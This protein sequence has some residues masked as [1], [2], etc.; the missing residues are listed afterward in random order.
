[1]KEPV[2]KDLVA[3]FEGE[4]SRCLPRF[5]RFYDP[6]YVDLHLS[7]WAWTLSSRLTFFLLISAAEDHDEFGVE[8]AWSDDG[9]FPWRNPARPGNRLE[10]LPRVRE[11]LSF[12]WVNKVAYRWAVIPRLKW[13]DHQAKSEARKRGDME[14]VRRLNSLQDVPMDEALR[15]IGPLVNDAVQKPWSTVFRCSDA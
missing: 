9:L 11:D 7:F 6:N 4:M 12:L 13:K 8:I 10:E 14:E 5:K 15:R 2:L 1:M 3:A